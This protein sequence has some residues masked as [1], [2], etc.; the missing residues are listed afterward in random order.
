MIT[1]EER[2]KGKSDNELVYISI[3]ANNYKPDFIALVDAELARRNISIDDLEEKRA[4]A[5]PHSPS[6]KEPAGW[7]V[8]LG[9]LL[10]IIQLLYS[11][12]S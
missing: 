1:D 5:K 2:I 8:G 12:F 10:G 6:I 11:L 7:V 9:A 3:H 4:T